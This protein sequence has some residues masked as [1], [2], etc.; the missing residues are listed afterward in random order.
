MRIHARVPAIRNCKLLQQSRQV[1][2]AE[3]SVERRT[4]LARTR[5]KSKSPPPR[6]TAPPSNSASLAAGS[7][8]SGRDHRTDD[9][10]AIGERHVDYFVERVI[11]EMTVAELIELIEGL[12]AELNQSARSIRLNT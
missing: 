12:A 11:P 6:R 5:S 7:A 3:W 4:T 10:R 1:T 2:F 8:S 9:G